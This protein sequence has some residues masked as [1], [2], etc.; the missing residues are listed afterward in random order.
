MKK[1]IS[2]IAVMIVIMISSLFL[3]AQDSAAAS[4]KK[5]SFGLGFGIPYGGLG[6]NIDFN[7]VKNLYFTGGFGYV[8]TAGYNFGV[9][10]FLAP[11]KNNFRPTI[12]VYYGVNTLEE[13]R[14][15]GLKSYHGVSLGIGAQWMWG[16][17]GLNFDIIII[18]YSKRKVGIENRIKISIGYRRAF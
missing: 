17:N 4:K 10:Y 1:L 14:W 2:V 13:S 5:H 12:S 18:T 6:A 11:I 7:V 3:L 9:K 16:N 15:K 8:G